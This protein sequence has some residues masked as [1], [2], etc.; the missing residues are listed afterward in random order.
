LE[1]HSSKTV[2][3]GTSARSTEQHVMSRRG[4]RTT[5]RRQ[6]ITQYEMG[7]RFAE[8]RA[9]EGWDPV[10]SIGP[11]QAKVSSSISSRFQSNEVS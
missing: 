11:H 7:F 1:S 4:A 2:S 10:G 9:V 5:D 8:G 3:T 6:G